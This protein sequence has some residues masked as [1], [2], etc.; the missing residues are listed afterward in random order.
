MGYSS[1]RRAD[2]QMHFCH[3]C[4]S[5]TRYGADVLTL[6][7][8][9]SSVRSPGDTEKNMEN[10]QLWMDEQ[11]SEGRRVLVIKMHVYNQGCLLGLLSHLKFKSR[12]RKQEG[13]SWKPWSCVWTLK[14]PVTLII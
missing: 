3:T 4:V 12:W 13:F 1:F 5:V 7:I 2:G 8:A 9:R 10:V 11:C 6:E 14:T